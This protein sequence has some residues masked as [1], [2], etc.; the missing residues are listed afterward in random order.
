MATNGASFRKGGAQE[1]VEETG[2]N[3]LQ[4][5]KSSGA[6]TITPEMFEKL[7]LT[8]KV[9]STGDFRR[10]FANPTPLGLMG[11]IISATT[12]AAIMMGWGGST[13]LTGVVGIFYFTGPVLLILATIFEWIV[14]N[15]LSMMI[16]GMFAV[17]WLSFGVLQT[18]SWGIAASYSATG[19]AAQGAASVGYNAAVAL[20]LTVWGFWLFTTM[21]FTLKTNAVDALIFLF[22]CISSFILSGAY[23]KVSTGDFATAMKLQKAG[24]ATFFV[25]AVLGWYMTVVIMAAEMRMTV[26]LPVGDLS[27]LWPTDVHLSEMEKKV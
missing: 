21:I 9:T 18:P 17:F 11:F 23:W 27:H 10:R 14:G 2:F 19:D 20:Y 4:Q 22:A 26:K 8:P 16:M 3:Y 12:F 7:Y 1:E 25:L 24:G 13:T 6:M 15:F 5:I